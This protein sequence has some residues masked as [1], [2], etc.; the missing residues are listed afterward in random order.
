MNAASDVDAANT[1][2]L[3]FAFTNEAIDDDAASVWVLRYAASDVEAARIVTLLLLL[4]KAARE[5]EA[6]RSCASVLLF[7][8]PVPVVIAEARELVAVCISER[9]AKEPESSP[10]PVSVRLTDAQTAEAVS[11]TR[12]PKEVRVRPL[13]DQIEAGSVA[14]KLDEADKTAAP[15]LALMTAEREDVAT[16]RLSSTTPLIVLVETTD[17]STIKLLS[18]ITKS[19]LATVPQIITDGQTPEGALSAVV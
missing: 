1:V 18:T 15:V 6:A 7:T 16:V 13:N 4:M 8:V 19:P 14:N 5:V 11:A 2:V 9:V 3:V 17:Q 10:A 12:V